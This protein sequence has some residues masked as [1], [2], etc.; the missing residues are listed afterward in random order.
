V[1]GG[2]KVDLA[3]LMA[4]DWAEAMKPVGQDIAVALTVFDTAT[5]DVLPSRLDVLKAFATPLRDVRVLIVGQDPY[6]TR[7]HAMGLAFSVPAGMRPLPPSL[8]NLLTE[9]HH[10]IGDPMSGH[11]DLTAWQEQGVMLMN[12]V[13]TVAEGRSG[14]HRSLGWEQVTDHAARALAG[15]G[16]PLVAVLWGRHA[17]ELRHHLP[18][19]A[20]VVSA[21]P[22]PLSARRGFFGSRPFSRVNSLLA[23]QGSQAVDWSLA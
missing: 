20:T 18:G 1:I 19:V 15:R 7:G 3:A 4:P 22:S 11:G 17:Q 13:L 21:H 23:A 9:L 12:R 16:G 2:D 10:D 8:R 14:S 6:P 5:S